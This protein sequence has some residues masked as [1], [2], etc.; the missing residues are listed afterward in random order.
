MADE[1]LGFIGLG[2]MGLPMAANLVK[3][4]E[5]H[6]VA[7]FKAEEF[8]QAVG[9]DPKTGQLAVKDLID[10]FQVASADP[11]SFRPNG[12]RKIQF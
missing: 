4:A 8:S 11:G 1:Q 7:G 9:W 2:N 10:F 12:V 6:D 5:G 3:L